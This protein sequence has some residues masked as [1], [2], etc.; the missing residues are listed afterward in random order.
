MVLGGLFHCAKFGCCGVSHRGNSNGFEVKVGMHQGSALSPLLFVIFTETLQ[1]TEF[2]V[3]L[4]CELLYAYDMVV[5][6]ETK[7]DLIKS[8]MSGR[9]TWRMEV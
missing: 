3:A 5:T 7:D 4:Q 8:L 6:A 2:R 9:I 1:C